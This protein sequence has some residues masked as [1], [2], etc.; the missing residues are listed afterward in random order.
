MTSY[1]K[2]WGRFSHKRTS[3][4]TAHELDQSRIVVSASGDEASRN[5]TVLNY[6]QNAIICLQAFRPR[7]STSR[8]DAEACIGRYFFVKSFGMPRRLLILMHNT[9]SMRFLQVPANL[10]FFIQK[11]RCRCYHWIGWVMDAS[12]SPLVQFCL[13]HSRHSKALVMNNVGSSHKGQKILCPK[14][15]MNGISKT[16]GCLHFAQFI[17]FS[18]HKTN[19][20]TT[21][22][23]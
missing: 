4:A 21:C 16:K 23:I 11:R 3:L 12:H 2:L 1:D 8:L 20:N 7:T 19:N 6:V 22:T 14:L 17:P 5:A 18:L 10:G 13:K 9:T 15:Y